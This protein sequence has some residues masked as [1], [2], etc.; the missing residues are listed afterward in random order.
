M[1]QGA[2]H[3]LNTPNL[4]SDLR[5]RSLSTARH[6]LHDVVQVRTG[7]AAAPPAEF[8]L[9]LQFGHDLGIRRVAVDVDHPGPRMTRSKQVILEEAL[10]GR[11]V[12]KLDMHE[13]AMVRYCGSAVAIMGFEYAESARPIPV[14]ADRH[15]RVDE[16]P[17]TA[18]H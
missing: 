12:R 3:R 16:P 9:L 18:G 8:A 13:D 4:H 2:I 6:L 15:L 17:A 10:G 11:M 7:T 5:F 1:V 14:F